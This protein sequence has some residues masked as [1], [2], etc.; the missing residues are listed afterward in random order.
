MFVGK[1][2]SLPWSGAPE[3]CFTRIGSGLTQKHRTRLEKNAS[4]K[5]SNLFQKS[6]NYGHKKFYNIEPG[7]NVVITFVVQVSYN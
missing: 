2:R 5:H 4:D 7:C 3:M 1:A 6:E